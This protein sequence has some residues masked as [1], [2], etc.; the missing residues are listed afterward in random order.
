MLDQT[1]I[2][3]IE[4]LLKLDSGT[5][6]TAISSDKEEALTLPEGLKVMT[7]SELESRDKS[8]KNRSYNE[9]KEAGADMTI[10]SIKNN[11]G[12][13]IEGK[14][15]ESVMSAY[16]EKVLSDAK[17]KPAEALQEKERQIAALRDNVNTLTQ[18]R[19][20]LIQEK[21][22]ISLRA[23]LTSGVPSDLPVDQDEFLYSMNSKG[24]EFIEEEGKIVVKKNGQPLYTDTTQENVDW[25]EVM[26]NYAKERWGETQPNKQGMGGKSSSKHAGGGLITKMSQLEKQF[27]D[28]GKSTQGSEFASAFQQAQ[29]EAEAA[30]HEFKVDE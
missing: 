30:G 8:L 15:L 22:N 17:I 10:K 1:T 11:Y 4:K 14:D 13:D 3:Q 26:S 29:K 7:E 20:S 24:Y 18:E 21:N 6:S 23:K 12:I 16:N 28:A 9:G 25:K 2:E 19:E 5:L 27:T